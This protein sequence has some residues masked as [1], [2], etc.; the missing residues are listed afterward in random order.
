MIWTK[1]ITRYLNNN[2]NYFNCTLNRTFSSQKLKSYK[3]SHANSEYSAKS[4]RLPLDSSKNLVVK[5]FETDL[6]FRRNQASNSILFKIENESDILSLVE[7]LEIIGSK[8]SNILVLDE[9]NN[10]NS[11]AVLIEFTSKT[12][13]DLILDNNGVHFSNNDLLPCK[14]RLFVYRN[15]IKKNNPKNLNKN[16]PIKKYTYRKQDQIN[17]QNVKL[18]EKFS[19]LNPSETLDKQIM[20]IYDRFKLDEIGIRIR[21]FI[22]SV[23]EES[24]LS[25]FRNCLCLPFGSS[26]VNI[27]HQTSD[28]DL[29][30]SIDNTFFNN[31]IEEKKN[32]RLNGKMIFY[33]KFN[34]NEKERAINILGLSKLILSDIIPKFNVKQL[35][36]SARVPILEFDFEL[37]S[38]QKLNCDL[39]MS[40]LQISFQMTKLFWTFTQID[41]R[42]APLIFFLKFWAKSTGVSNTFRPSP[43][44]TNFQLTVLILNFLLRLDKP[45]IVPL[46]SVTSKIKENDFDSGLTYLINEN[47]NLSDINGLIKEK[48]K[49]T[50]KE[51][52]MGFFNYYSNFDFDS[53]VISLSRQMNMKTDKFKHEALVILNPFMPEVNASK[54]VNR[55]LLKKFT[56]FCNESYGFLQ[57]NHLIDLVQ[58]FDFL[59]KKNQEFKTMI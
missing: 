8:V 48:N 18:S 58:F 2:I 26:A 42:I 19:F 34:K 29:L 13:I 57:T 9:L 11:R 23:I 31:Q 47:L 39:S 46:E 50:L 15:Q 17:N 10:L 40:N 43:N 44:I 33:S 6:S 54:N 21:F 25:I 35:I 41:N 1:I 56:L 52:L 51:L 32:Y 3:K 14:T 30:F 36:K 20:M 28:L 4:N 27:G 7:D 38:G 24:F 59:N 53:N 16:F 5:K 55:Q 22:A 12:S 45:L 37:P 49:L